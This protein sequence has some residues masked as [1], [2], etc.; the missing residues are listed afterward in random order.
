MINCVVVASTSGGVISK[1]LEVPY[2]KERVRCVVSDRHC[3]AIDVANTFGIPIIIHATNDSLEF[4]NFLLAEFQNN[5]PDMF[6]SFYTRLFK[7]DFL[8]FAKRKLINLH[9]SILPACAGQNGFG[10]TIKSGSKF[11]GATI[12][13]VDEGV[14]TGFP[15][16][17]SAAPIDPN[18]PVSESRHRVF[19][20]QCKMLLQ[21]IKWEE[22]NRILFD[23]NGRPTI[24]EA[25][26]SI[27]EFSPNLDLDI[28]IEFDVK[29]KN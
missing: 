17:Q 3:G 6:V 12:H 19:V 18:K 2:F 21:V 20:Q 10:D 8:S 27:G 14:D 15:I 25:L 5:K 1:L 29:I 22:D 9:P 13:L 28:A 16:I 11:I 26:Y 4:S 24:S 23:E 7:G